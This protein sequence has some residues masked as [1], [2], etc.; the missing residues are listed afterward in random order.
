[1]INFALVGAVVVAVTLA[2]FAFFAPFRTLENSLSDILHVAF[3]PR[4]D[5][6]EDII[7]VTITEDTLATLPYRS[8][9]DRD[10]LADLV[11]TLLAH[12]PKGVAIDLLFDQPTEAAKDARLR[13]VISD[14]S[15]PI[16]AAFATEAENLTEA[17]AN[18]LSA[19]LGGALRGSA[20]LVA[21][22]DDDVVR[23]VGAPLQTE[24]GL[25]PPLGASIFRGELTSGA[26]ARRIAF[27][28]PEDISQGRFPRY[29]A[30]TV[31]FLPGDWI[32]GKY[33]LI[34]GE[35]PMIDRFL[36][37]INAVTGGGARM[38]GVEIHA[39]YLQQLIDGRG[40][41]RASPVTN[42]LLAALGALLAI[43][44][45]RSTAPLIAKLV[46]LACLIAL[47]VTLAALSIRHLGV[48]TAVAA[49]TTATLLAAAAVMA[50]QWRRERRQRAFIR[51]TFSRFVSPAVVDQLIEDPDRIRRKPEVRRI[52]CIFTDVAGF[53][54][55]IEKNRGDLD[56]TESVLNEY[57]SEM[58]EIYFANDA[59]IDKFIGDA[60][61]GFFGAPLPVED[62][63]QRALDLAV[64]LNRFAQ[65]FSERQ[66]AEKGLVFGETRI[67]IHT[68]E[69][70]LGNFGSDKFFDY[71]AIGDTMNTA[72]RLESANKT[73]GTRV[74][75]SEATRAETQPPPHRPIGNVQFKGKSEYL[76]VYELTSAETVAPQDE[77]H[78]AF[79]A[80]KTGGSDALHRFQRLHEAYPDDRLVAFH[81]ERLQ[82]GEENANVRMTGK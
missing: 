82:S 44:L 76:P 80:M 39:H 36:T 18:Y 27:Q 53:T 43:A 70:L 72:A 59:T 15:A 60:I 67:G 22:G 49:P 3:Y 45:F 17:Q 68:G 21:D 10:F 33:V 32:A 81:L 16:T 79:A 19:F 42:G 31:R 38:S 63:A 2:G 57:L 48:S 8:P 41:A 46:A 5:I 1:M 11:E 12:G 50:Q 78:A 55:F 52:T 24:T 71:T 56:L 65:A 51:T 4:A 20:V 35:L 9:V 14:G 61:V 62:H 13:S 74:C 28:F 77:Y 26:A 54:S 69:V 66:L 73:F 25:A 47:G 6:S 23:S 58:T 37:P 29:P 75:F 7:L 30:H 64:E 34:G 40:I